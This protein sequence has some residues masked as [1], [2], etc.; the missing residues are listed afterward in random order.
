MASTVRNEPNCSHELK[1]LGSN[2]IP[3]TKHIAVI[4]AQKQKAARE[5]GLLF[6]QHRDRAAGRSHSKRRPGR[7]CVRTTKARSGLPCSRPLPLPRQL[8]G[9]VRSAGFIRFRSTVASRP[10]KISLARRKSAES[11]PS[12]NWA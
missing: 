12:V 5:G 2:P 9:R 10:F 4:A 3:A 7:A 8:S 11:N 6:V 1:A